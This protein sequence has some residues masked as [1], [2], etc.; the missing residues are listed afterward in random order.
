ME[1][2]SLRLLVVWASFALAACEDG[3]NQPFNP[4]PPNA[5]D[6]WNNG[7]TPPSVDD[8]G[9]PYQNTVGGTNKQEICTGDKKAM[10]WA[11]MVLQPIV[12]PTTAA[13]IDMTGGPTWK[14]I[15]I[16]QAEK[17]NCQS[18]SLGDYFGDGNLT[19]SWGDN[20]EVVVEYRV[21]DHKV[22]F[23]TLLQGYMGTMAF[24]SPDGKHQ[25]TIQIAS[26]VSKDGRPF[27]LD[28][29]GNNGKNFIPQAD[30]LYRGLMHTY[31]PGL[32]L[33][34]NS[35]CFDSGRCIK[36]DF[37]D[38]AYLYIPA[39]GWGFWID[40]QHAQQPVPSVPTRLDVYLTKIMP[41]AF[42]TPD[43][44]M[45]AVGPVAAAGKLGTSAQPCTL[46]LGL[47]YSDFLTTCVQVDG[48]AQKNQDELNKLLGGMSHDTQTWHFDVSGIDVD[49]ISASLKDDDVIHDVDL[50][51]KTDI[52]QDLYMDQGTLG[53]IA[54]DYDKNGKKDL[55][56]AGAV[57]KEYLRQARTDLL[58]EAGVPDGDTSKCLFPVPPPKGFDPQAF[59]KNLPPYCTGLE[60]MITAAPPTA[61]GDPNNIGM[62]AVA[63]SPAYS[64]CLKFGHLVGTFC[65]DANGDLNTGYRYCA[66]PYGASG[67]IL[68]T[69]YS[70]VLNIFAH[71][72]VANL[73]PDVQDNRFF[74]KA[75]ATALTKYF[76][77]GGVDPVPDL[78]KIVLNPDNQFFD[79]QGAG[80]FEIYEFVD[81]RFATK[82]QAPLDFQMV[83]DVK[84][85]IFN[86]YDFTRGLLRGESAIYQAMLENPNDGIGQEESALL[87]NVV[88]SPVL[89]SGWTASSTA[90]L[91]MPCK[92]DADC[93]GAYCSEIDPKT[94]QGTCLFSAYYCATN[95]DPDN[96]DGQIPPL[97]GDGKLLL[98]EVNRPLLAQYKGAFMD[99]PP[100]PNAAVGNTVFALG[101][102]HFKILQ[103]YPNI[104]SAMVE[105]STYTDPYNQSS[106]PGPLLDKLVPWMPNQPGVGF[107]IDQNGQIDK[108][109]QTYQ[110]DFSG[111]TL[112]AN[113]DY[114]DVLDP[115]T[116]QPT[117]RYQILAVETTDFLGRVF[118]CQDPATTDLLD[119]R[120]YT[121][122]EK[123]VDW[124]K[125][126]PGAYQAC[127]M[128]FRYS[129]YNNYLDY[130]TSIPNGVRLGITQGGGAGR[131]VDV[132]LFMPGQ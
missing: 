2:R 4:S 114:N 87:T 52:A 24:T 75:Y 80:Q 45:D 56:G 5:G 78:S 48:D 17:I 53:A 81:R 86:S 28:W 13:G 128:I 106:K 30:E 71:G 31:A 112:S 58:A 101:Y 44:R 19:N 72:K 83:V 65:A 59:L 127:G 73:P 64:I 38:V 126:H 18:D 118:L 60:G 88:G 79:S 55:H 51:T 68:S 85:G 46:Q 67:D 50:P 36:G 96:C 129:P 113:I 69:S 7:H 95:N 99:T 107:P 8:A 63:I 105:I 1:R 125:N 102:D 131:V 11:N 14:G 123:I 22:L 49:Y 15:T 54:N 41:Y 100:Q 43:V 21:T 20:Q 103:E 6:N 70:Q 93:T 27:T 130:I 92:V 82:V 117:G 90:K 116:Q 10:V 29:T 33:D 39:L 57:Y 120:M 104:Q 47:S 66:P 115:N 91:N 9:Q 77:V 89:A 34:Q 25:Y 12:P 121:P 110:A 74:F 124:F 98:D 111:V 108:F 132:T 84:N 76:T 35:T 61:P 3:P 97:D 37:G 40:N 62:A 94:K 42:A 122:A 119:V 26:Q 23:M 109:V 32:P 16:E